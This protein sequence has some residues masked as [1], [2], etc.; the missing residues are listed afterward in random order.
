MQNQK[1]IIVH[2]EALEYQIAWDEGEDIIIID[3]FVVRV[4]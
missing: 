3:I 2:F 4:S 1:V